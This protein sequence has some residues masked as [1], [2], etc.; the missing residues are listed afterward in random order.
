MISWKGVT[1]MRSTEGF[2]GLARLG[3]EELRML[4]QKV[5]EQILGLALW[6]VSED[7][8]ERFRKHLPE[9][10]RTLVEEERAFHGQLADRYF[11][12]AKG[13]LPPLQTFEDV[14]QLTDREIQTALREIDQEDAPKALLGASLS[15]QEKILTNM[16]RRVREWLEGRMQELAALS[17]EEIEA[18]QQRFLKAV[19]AVGP[20][21]VVEARKQVQKALD[22]QEQIVRVWRVQHADNAT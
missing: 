10:V 20:Q 14:L 12:D 11:P 16:S 6:V 21:V 2:A 15:T 8:L 17:Q 13:E 4:V 1:A 9:K 22:A 5:D 3:D 19:S 7:L 18:A